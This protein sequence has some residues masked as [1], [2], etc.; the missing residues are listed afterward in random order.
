MFFR[1]RTRPP[2]PAA[3]A[4]PLPASLSFS[5]QRVEREREGRRHGPLDG[6]RAR[7]RPASHTPPSHH[8]LFFVSPRPRTVQERRRELFDDDDDDDDVD[9]DHMTTPSACGR[10]GDLL[11]QTPAARTHT[12][13]AHARTLLWRRHTL[14][15]LPSLSSVCALGPWLTSSAFPSCP[16][17]LPKSFFSVC[18]PPRRHP[19]SPPHPHLPCPAPPQRRTS[20]RSKLAHN[21]TH[22]T[23]RTLAPHTDRCARARAQ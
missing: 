1:R 21:T 5:H 9:Y 4:L 10:D 18:V 14:S 3:G 15:L 2:R 8:P 11:A 12:A 17:P 20:T 13:R 19:P 16:P 6:S 22:T 23:D 7:R